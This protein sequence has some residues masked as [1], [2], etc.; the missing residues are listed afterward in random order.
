M[1]RFQK[2]LV[3][4]MSIMATLLLITGCLLMYLAFH[5]CPCTSANCTVQAPPT[6]IVAVP[7]EKP[8]TPTVV[9]VVPAEKHHVAKRHHPK[10]VPAPKTPTALPPPEVSKPPIATAEAKPVPVLQPAP[11]TPPSPPVEALPPPIAAEV[12]PK[13]DWVDCRPHQPIKASCEPTAEQ[14]QRFIRLGNTN[15]SVPDVMANEGLKNLVC[16][17]IQ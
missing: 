8:C 3:A 9:P 6:A 15:L 14:V 10:P 17:L 2:F 16:H 11:V 1:S 13:S 12:K 4:I 7:A 5:L